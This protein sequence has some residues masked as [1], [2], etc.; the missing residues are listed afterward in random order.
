MFITFASYSM[1]YVNISKSIY[2]FS[3][4]KYY[5]S[6]SRYHIIVSSPKYGIIFLV[7]TGRLV[8]HKRFTRTTVSSVIF[9]HT[10]SIKVPLTSIIRNENETHHPNRENLSIIYC[11]VLHLFYLISLIALTG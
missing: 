4:C 1:T 8:C 5:D 6:T 11:F 7:R 3:L 10:Y 2:L 9:W